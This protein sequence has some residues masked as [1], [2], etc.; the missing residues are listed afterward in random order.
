M[1]GN[2]QPPG[3]ETGECSS[4]LR[5][6]VDLHSRSWFRTMSSIA[7]YEGYSLN[8][9]ID[10]AA[11]GMVDT[12]VDTMITEADRPGDLTRGKLAAESGR[13]PT[14]KA[15]SDETVGRG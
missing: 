2:Q 3:A 5:R 4:G 15:S 1:N 8:H 6:L 12:R 11:V 14:K 10:D 13:W 9:R 7:G